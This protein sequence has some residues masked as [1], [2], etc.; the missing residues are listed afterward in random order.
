M[1]DLALAEVKRECK[2]M[3]ERLA[4]LEADVKTRPGHWNRPASSAV[5]RQSMDL[6]RALAKLR[7]S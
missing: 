2:R 6:T 7:R 3:L 4:D 5:R 1:R